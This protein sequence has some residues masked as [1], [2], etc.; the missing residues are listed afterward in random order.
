LLSI[1]NIGATIFLVRMLV[2]TNKKWNLETK[3]DSNNKT[4]LDYDG[5]K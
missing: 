5:E 1:G 4:N 3:Q 2:Q